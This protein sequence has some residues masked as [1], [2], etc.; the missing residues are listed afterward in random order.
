MK[1]RPFPVKPTTRTRHHRRVE[2]AVDLIRRDPA[3]PF[4]VPELARAAALSEFHFHRVFKALTGESVAACIA[5]HRLEAAASALVYHPDRP[6]TDIALECGF[7]SSANFARAFT[8]AYGCAPTRFRRAQTGGDRNSR[9]GKAAPL[10]T[11]YAAAMSA[12]V[13]IVHLPARTL[14]GIRLVGAFSHAR[15]SRAY[16]EAGLWYQSQFGRPPPDEA[17]SLTWSDTA[18]AAQESWRLDACYSVPEGTQG[19]GRIFVRALAGGWTARCRFML[20]RSDIGRI[21][22]QWDWLLAEWLPTSGAELDARPAYETY[23]SAGTGDSF[24][25]ALCLPLTHRPNGVRP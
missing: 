3:H 14:A 21:A 18:L 5:R 4:T 10:E 17:I 9:L 11:G 7:S 19:C 15:I 23:R 6:V 12:V 8:R 16:G 13:D 24:D 1:P 22:A 2:Q 20:K 25:V